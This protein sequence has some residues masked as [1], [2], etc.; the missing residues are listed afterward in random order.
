DTGIAG[1]LGGGI[2]WRGPG[3]HL[4]LTAAT[5][6][7]AAG[8]DEQRATLSVRKSSGDF[9]LSLNLAADD[10]GLDTARLLHGEWRF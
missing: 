3:L 4:R 1:D 10:A 7:A 6:V 2:E 5:S 9:A 8:P